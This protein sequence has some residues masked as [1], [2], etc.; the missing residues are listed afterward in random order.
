MLF[1]TDLDFNAEEGHY[2][3][4]KPAKSIGRQPPDTVAPSW[5]NMDLS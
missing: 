3:L 4:S 2:V 1:L 5:N